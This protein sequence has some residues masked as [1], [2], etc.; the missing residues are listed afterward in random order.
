MRFLILCVSVSIDNAR[1]VW[2]GTKCGGSTGSRAVFRSLDTTNGMVTTPF[3]P[4]SMTVRDFYGWP[5]RAELS[6][7]APTTGRAGGAEVQD[8]DYVLLGKA[9]ACPAASVLAWRSRTLPGQRTARLVCTAKGLCIR[10]P[11]GGSPGR[12]PG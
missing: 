6:G 7:T 3:S 11:M 8:V 9:M 5:L 12:S 10:I 2:V 4:C 1:N